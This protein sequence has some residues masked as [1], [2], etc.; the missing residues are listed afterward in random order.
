MFRYRHRQLADD[1][2]VHRH[3][4]DH[5]LTPITVAITGASGLVG[6]QLAAFLST[7]GHRVIRLVRHPATKPDERQWNPESPDPALLAGVDAV[8]HLAGESIAGRFT[9]QHRAAIRD[10]RIGPTRRLAEL[11]AQ[12]SDGPKVLISASAIG[13]YGYDRGE[14]A[15]TEDSERGDGFLADVVA[16]WEDATAPAEQAGTRV[17]RVRTGI[18]QSPAGGTLR[19]FRPLFS[20]GLGGRLGSG[21]QWLSWIGIDDLVDVYH[22]GLWDTDLSGP[23][24]AVAPEPARNVDYTRTLAHVL[25]RPALLPV[26]PLGPRLLLGKQGARELACA[27]QRVL[28]TRLQQADHRFRGPDLEQTLRHL[29]GHPPA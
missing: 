9:D 26:P 10:S 12:S 28:P 22:R 27:N 20:A 6:S 16:D 7:G 3:A 21:Q 17:V 5:G 14:E 23:V 19:L 25:H 8:I 15:L 13:Y 1:L 24:N 4:A 18:V 11:I 2:A 29:L